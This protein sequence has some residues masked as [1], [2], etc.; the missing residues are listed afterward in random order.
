MTVNCTGF[1][2]TTFV[3]LLN[4]FFFLILLLFSVCLL[5]R[6]N[7]FISLAVLAAEPALT[8][9]YIRNH[10]L[11]YLICCFSVFGSNRLNYLV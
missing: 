5:W 9:S 10:I 1:M 2:V 4:Y 11:M 7:V 6:I 3:F 8:A